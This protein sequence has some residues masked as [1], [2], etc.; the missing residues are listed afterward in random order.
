M[1]RKLVVAVALLA[2]VGLAAATV[3]IATRPA[4]RAR[5]HLRRITPGEVRLVEKSG[6]VALDLDGHALAFARSRAARRL[7]RELVALAED[8]A[9][10]DEATCYRAL[11]L[12]SEPLA[13]HDL[14]WEWRGAAEATGPRSQV[15]VPRDVLSVMARSLESRDAR[16]RRWTVAHLPADPRVLRAMIRYL[17]GLAPR[18]VESPE[19]TT[20][21]LAWFET[22][23]L[24][25]QRLVQQE[26]RRDAWGLFPDRD[27]AV[28][29]GWEGVTRKGRGLEEATAAFERWLE[30]YRRRLPEQVR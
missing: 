25:N 29:M 5:Y 30:A 16:L 12:Q 22:F 21:A 7:L 2:L 13:G 18:A 24:A 6:R 4:V 9:A 27:W 28:G 15:P 11:L 17:H 3:F 26:G 14:A 19:E 10:L 1:R 8:E 20:L 23:T